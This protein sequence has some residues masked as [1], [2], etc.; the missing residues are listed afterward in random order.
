MLRE[1]DGYFF[2]R[3]TLDNKAGA[4][5][6]VANMVQWKRDRS[7]PARDV[8]MVLTCDEETTA[9]QGMQWLLQ[10]DPRLRTADYALNTDAGGVTRTAGGRYVVNTQAAEK[11][12][13]TFTLAV[14]PPLRPAPGHPAQ[15]QHALD[16]R[17]REPG[18]PGLRPGTHS[19]MRRL[20]VVAHHLV[21]D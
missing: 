17:R 12:Y 7:V 19:V 13:A 5:V 6:L 21:Q 9:E 4:S 16:R 10:R 3:G 14:A 20:V 18:Q 11:V 2:G 1:A 15:G 8:V